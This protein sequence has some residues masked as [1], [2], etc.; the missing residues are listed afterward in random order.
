MRERASLGACL[1]VLALVVC[2]ACSSGT[3][4]KPEADTH[5]SSPTFDTAWAAAHRK[6]LGG[7]HGR[8]RSEVLSR[9]CTQP[10]VGPCV[11]G[12]SGIIDSGVFTLHPDSSSYLHV[13]FGNGADVTEIAGYQVRNLVNFDTFIQPAGRARAPRCWTPVSSRL[14][15]GS[16]WGFV[17]G[18]EVVNDAEPVHDPRLGDRVE[19]LIGRA[20]AREV[21]GFLGVRDLDPYDEFN[22]ADGV[23]PVHLRMDAHGNASGFWVDGEEVAIALVGPASDSHQSNDPA[24]FTPAKDLSHAAA[25]R[26]SLTPLHGDFRMYDF[27]VTPRVTAPRPCPARS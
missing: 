4:K 21:L 10:P 1:A 18:F 19:E 15:F 13:A 11:V 5:R 16:D 24:A 23:V 14:E 27:N 9:A 3:S 8:F 26:A 7:V 6:S 17:S 20:P 2:S 25:I 22:E 12:G